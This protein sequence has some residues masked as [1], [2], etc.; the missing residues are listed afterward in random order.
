MADSATV[1]NE[2]VSA[3]SSELERLQGTRYSLDVVLNVSAPSSVTIPIMTEASPVLPT[4]PLGTTPASAPTMTPHGA[5]E[6]AEGGFSGAGGLA[7]LH[8]NELI[9]PEK[10][11]QR[12]FNKPDYSI[13]AGQAAAPVVIENRVYIEGREIDAA[14]RRQQRLRNHQEANDGG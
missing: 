4:S 8:P 2:Q 11:W 5:T 10:I 13:G 9:L 1:A 7:R 6:F 14:S 3:L 12:L